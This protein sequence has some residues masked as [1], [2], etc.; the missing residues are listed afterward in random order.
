MATVSNWRVPRY[1]VALVRD[2]SAKWE[3]YPRFANSREI[4]LALKE[5]MASYDREKFFVFTL[6][7][8]NKL[9]GCHEV[10]TGSL[11]DSIVH[12]RE[13]Y[14]AAILNSA[15]SI[16]LVHNHPSG[17]CAPS[18]EDRDCTNRLVKAGQILGIRVLDHIV[19]GLEDYF[20]FCDCGLMS[21]G[22]TEG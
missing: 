1:Q 7:C 19:I 5:E 6:D 22:Q 14:K 12:P 21:L 10:S 2:G 3:T 15:A 20:S 11:S 13:V 16:I 9:I 4:F 8:K 18:K 17:D